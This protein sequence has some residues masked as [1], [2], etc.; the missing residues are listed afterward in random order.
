ML[1]VDR[2]ET[3]D[4]YQMSCRLWVHRVM[5]D[6][7]SYLRRADML[8]ATFIVII[9]NI[10]LPTPNLRLNICLDDGCSSISLQ[11]LVHIYMYL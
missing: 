5:E 10:E 6:L 3:E 7:H 11:T 4:D 9:A 1:L 2:A 8:M